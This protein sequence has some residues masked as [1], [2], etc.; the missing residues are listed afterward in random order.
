VQ[1]VVL[2]CTYEMLYVAFVTSSKTDLNVTRYESFL[3]KHPHME[4]G[5]F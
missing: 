3:Q 4:D 5:A 1:V 2:K